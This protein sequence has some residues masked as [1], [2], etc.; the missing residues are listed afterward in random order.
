LK[1]ERRV[2]SVF[3]CCSACL[4]VAEIDI[5]GQIPGYFSRVSP[6][7]PTVSPEKAGQLRQAHNDRSSNTTGLKLPTY[8]PTAR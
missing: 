2:Q 4:F 3:Y 5:Q 1:Q 7:E 8:P 6:E